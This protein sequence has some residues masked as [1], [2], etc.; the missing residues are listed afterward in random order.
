MNDDGERGEERDVISVDR[1]LLALLDRS[2]S[3]SHPRDL[4]RL[5]G[6]AKG[7]SV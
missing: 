1:L 2:D 3:A 4:M 5:R 6:E 7:N